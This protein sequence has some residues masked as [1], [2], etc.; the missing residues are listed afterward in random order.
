MSPATSMSARDR[1]DERVEATSPTI[2]LGTAELLER[3]EETETVMSLIEQL[4][5]DERSALILLGFGCSYKEI[6]ELRGWSKMKL[7]RCLAEGRARVREI[8]SRGDS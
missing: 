2:D 3:A 7:N 5:P 6:R 1:E 4:K 8:A